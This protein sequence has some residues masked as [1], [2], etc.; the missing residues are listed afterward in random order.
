MKV[1]IAGESS[2]HLQNYCHAIKK[3][4]DEIIL[5]TETSVQ[6]SEVK[7]SY[8]VSFR[9]LNPLKWFF[10]LQ[11]LKRIILEEKPDLVH[12]HQINRLAYF[13]AKSIH[14]IPLISTAWGSDVLLIPEKNFI[15][16]T[17]SRYVIRKSSVVTADARVMIDA[18]KKMD[19]SEIKYVHLQYG[20]DP[21][22]PFVKEK[23]IY[24]NRLHELL[25]NIDIIIKDFSAFSKHNPDWQ[26][27]IAGSGAETE[28]LKLLSS[29]LKISDKV[30]FLGWLKKEE[31]NANYARA[32]IYVSIPSSDGTSVSL[33]EA[34]SAN[35]IP[36]VSDLPVSKEWI[37]DGI[38]G[39]IRKENQNPF[40]EALNS[41][42]EKC[43]VINQEKINISTKREGTTKRFFEIYKKTLLK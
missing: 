7:K 35:C 27:H 26:L 41:N 22:V 10:N 5:V 43:F 15:F 24:S 28:K 18:M 29:E 2:V 37:R 21:V 34:M 13:I 12:V 32:S 23:I 40:E 38:N 4:V 3:H 6:I 1:L 31:N 17:L 19:N 11:K 33:L 36:V 30:K 25:Y 16:R 14:N 20:I 8:V 39:V 9:K 42:K